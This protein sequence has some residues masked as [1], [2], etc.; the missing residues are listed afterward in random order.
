MRLGAKTAIHRD[1]YFFFI[2]SPW[3]IVFCLLGLGFVIVNA[4]FAGLYMLEP[5]SISSNGATTFSSAF[6]FSVQTMCTIGYGALS[7]ES[8]YGN[9]LVTIEAAFSLVGVAVLTGVVFAKVS[10]P[11][12]AI[13]FSKPLLVTTMNGKKTLVFRAGNVRSNEIVGASVDFIVLRDDV[14][15]E[16][17]QTRRIY[18]LTVSRSRT[19]IFVLSWLVMHEID[20]KS[21]VRDIDFDNPGDISFVAALT[22]HDSTYGQTVYARHVWYPE[23]VRNNHRFVDIIDE[24]DDGRIQVDYNK[25]HDVLPDTPSKNSNAP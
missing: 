11:T 22:G 18:P 1:L 8:S 21:P 12:A 14:T 25:F 10:R 19:P 3:S 15:K 6:Y 16:G 23:D 13:V 24:T 20:E 17:H 9:L 7:P 5:H 2:R 4:A